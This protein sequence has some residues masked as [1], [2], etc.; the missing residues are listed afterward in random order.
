MLEVGVLPID[1][2]PRHG[3]SRVQ[4]EQQGVFHAFDIEPVAEPGGET[5]PWFDDDSAVDAVHAGIFPRMHR[6]V[7]G[8]PFLALA[9]RTVCRMS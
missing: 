9:D 4:R 3:H 8:A 2:Q 1:A 7:G 5:L 6:I